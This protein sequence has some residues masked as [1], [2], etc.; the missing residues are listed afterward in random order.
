MSFK[1]ASPER[2]RFRNACGELGFLFVGQLD[3]RPLKLE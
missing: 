3:G 1:T 2:N